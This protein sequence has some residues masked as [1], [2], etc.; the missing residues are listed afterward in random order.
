KTGR[1]IHQ[2]Q[3]STNELTTTK[4]RK[5]R[6]KREVVF[7]TRYSSP[8]SACIKT[9][10]SPRNPRAKYY[11]V[12]KYWSYFAV[13]WWVGACDEHL[14]NDVSLDENRNDCTCCR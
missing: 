9:T 1:E 7:F 2:R 4:S 14:G 11:M 10:Y 8:R 3:I 13:D 12:F 6:A 5:R